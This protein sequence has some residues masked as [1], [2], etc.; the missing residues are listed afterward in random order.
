MSAYVAVADDGSHHRS[1][2]CDAVD[3]GSV[4]SEVVTFGHQ[5]LDD[6]SSQ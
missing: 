5:D 2:H 3:W 1:F 6:C 4:L